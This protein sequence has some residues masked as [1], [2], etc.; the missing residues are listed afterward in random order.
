MAESTARALTTI[1]FTDVE[2]STD[3]S[4]RAGDHHTQDLM[5]AHEAIVRAHVTEHQGREP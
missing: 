2:G 1:L 3:L 4:T 5:R